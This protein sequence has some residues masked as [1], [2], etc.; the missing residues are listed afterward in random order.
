MKKT[1]IRELCLFLAIIILLIPLRVTA[2]ADEN[3]DSSFVQ[4]SQEGISVNGDDLELLVSG[5][6]ETFVTTPEESTVPVTERLIDFPEEELPERNIY[7]DSIS[8]TDTR[9]YTATRY[10]NCH[11]Y[12]WYSQDVSTNHYWMPDPHYYYDD[13]SYYEVATPIVGD[14]ICYFDDNGSVITTEDDNNLHSG[15]VVAVSASTTSNGLCGNSDTVTVESKWGEYGLYRHNGYQCPYTDHYLTVEPN[16]PERYLAEYVKYYRPVGHAHFF[17]TYNDTGNE[18]YHERICDC[19]MVV[20]EPHKWVLHRGN[21][22]KYIP[23]Y[24]CTDCGAFTL[25]PRTPTI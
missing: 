18:E 20:H 7:A 8:A 4:S 25:N 3:N 19:G 21:G 5:E 17:T 1:N 12:A 10:F 6:P 24:Y 16:V 9:L 2:Y 23:E 13:G 15:I 11:S 22:T 14:I